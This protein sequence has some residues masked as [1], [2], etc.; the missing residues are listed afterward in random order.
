MP[1]EGRLTPGALKGLPS[2]ASPGRTRFAATFLALS[3][4]AICVATLRSAGDT[5]PSG[6][7][8]SL[9]QGDEALAE[10]IQNLLLFIPFGAAL[11]LVLGSPSPEGRGGQGVRI[12]RRGGQGVRLL[13]AGL[14]LSFTVEFL[15]QWIPGRDPSLG[16]IATNGTS[17]LLGAAIVWTAPRWLHPP[18]HVAPWLSLGA[19]AVAAA[20]WL[21]TGWLLRPM[22]PLADALELRTPD[23]GGHTD[24]YTGRV[25]AVTGRIGVTEPLTIVVTAGT[26]AMSRRFAP[27][28][29]VDDG[30][31]PAGTIV[32][33]D[34][35]DLVLRNRSRSMFLHLARPDLRARDA[36]AGVAPGDT[37]TIT[38]W[39]HPRHR[40]FCLARDGKPSCGLG[41]TIGDG[42]KLIFFPDHF[43][44]W[45]LYVLNALWV[46]GGLLG[47]GLWGR[48]DRATG[49]ALLVA[50]LALALGPPLVGL[51]VT[52]ITEWLGGVGG[53]VLGLAWRRRSRLSSLSRPAP[54]PR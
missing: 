13:A 8:F 39:R 2:V 38:A 34:R 24:L 37:V 17:T 46:G 30:P 25:L 9:A 33:A 41:Y 50:A 14:A 48:R 51:T 18:E 4:L 36:L 47:V 28:L 49:I 40:T 42:W 44:T 52:P 21:G 12:E 32:A 15:Q 19:A 3:V 10:I 27:I 11:A 54:I 1:L 45:G 22:L 20:A 16:D 6:W 7:T 5:I 53:L 31:G 26:P 23:L 29:D 43:P 35:T